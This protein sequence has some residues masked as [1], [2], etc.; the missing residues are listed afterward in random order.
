LDSE[1]DEEQAIEVGA[2]EGGSGSEQ[3]FG[4]STWCSGHSTMPQAEQHQNDA[5][6]SAQ[7]H[8]ISECE[9][10]IDEGANDSPGSDIS[11]K[12]HKNAPASPA[13]ASPSASTSDEPY[14][15]DDD[16]SD[17]DYDDPHD[18]E[19][20]LLS[21]SS[22]WRTSSSFPHSARSGSVSHGTESSGGNAEGEYTSF[23]YMTS[24]GRSLK[25]RS[26]SRYN[27]YPALSSFENG[28]Y[29]QNGQYRHHAQE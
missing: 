5:P 12:Y 17:K 6:R 20:V 8:P 28:I 1:R 13:S 7:P 15:F 29:N 19:F 24:E 2:N 21:R 18:G 4:V 10:Q 14:E 11:G 27:P 26:A 25:P 16:K 3:S 23:Q 22:R 9:D